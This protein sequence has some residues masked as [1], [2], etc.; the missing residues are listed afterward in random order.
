MHSLTK[1]I[2]RV[3][4]RMRAALYYLAVLLPEHACAA[5]PPIPKFTDYP[6]EIYSGGW[7][8]PSS[9]KQDGDMW[10]D[11]MG[12]MVPPPSIN[13]AGKFY[14]AAHSCG[15]SCRYYT[16]TDL[17]NGRPSQALRLFSSQHASSKSSKIGHVTIVDLIT[18]PESFL[19]LARSYSETTDRQL[20]HCLARY[21]VL[22]DDGKFIKPITKPL[23]CSDN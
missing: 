10:R 2:N 22:S 23:E 15:T 8:L 6:A 9:I 14:I 19:V 11:N 3:N 7:M 1:S 20:P 18:H 16:L 12:K 17:S 21:F 5:N 4:S 13:T